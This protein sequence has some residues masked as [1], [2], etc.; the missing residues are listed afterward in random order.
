MRRSFKK[1][2]AARKSAVSLQPDAM[3]PSVAIEQGTNHHGVKARGAADEWDVQIILAMLRHAG[4]NDELV[5][6]LRSD[7]FRVA[8]HDEVNLVRGAINLSE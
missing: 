3:R 8:A 5:D 1:T 6:F 7:L 4:W 2:S